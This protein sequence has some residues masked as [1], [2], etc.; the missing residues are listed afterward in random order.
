LVYLLAG[1]RGGFRA[2]N[3]LASLVWVDRRGNE[4][5]LNVP[6]RGYVYPRISPDGTRLAVDLR[7]QDQD[8]WIWEF[9]RQTLTRLTFDPSLDGIPVWS[10]DGK[11]LVWSSQRGGTQLHLYWQAADG[12]G[13]AERL[14]DRSNPQRATG[15]TPDGRAIVLTEA[16]MGGQQD[17]V[18]LAVDEKRQVTSLVHSAFDEGNAVVAG[19]G[20]W[21]AY[22]SNESGQYQIYV[23]PFPAVDTGR[24]QVSTN[25]G[26]QPLWSRTGDELFYVD[27]TGALMRVNVVRSATGFSAAAPVKLINGTGYYYAWDDQNRGRTYDVSADGQRFVRIK[28]GP[29][30]NRASDPARFVIVENWT[31]ELKRQ[32]Q[33]R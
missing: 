15:F 14:T 32:V 13:M 2:G 6:P 17:I 31:E 1:A 19:D 18:M 23:R 29:L 12:T 3:P 27:P 4:Q 28:E 20:K 21:L 8:I 11:R 10:P 33:P 22:E 26:R 24:W 30:A 25:G 5:S 9:Q 7:D 16:Q